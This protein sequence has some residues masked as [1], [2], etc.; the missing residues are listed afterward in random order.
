MAFFG[1]SRGLADALK[2]LEAGGI[3]SAEEL[4]ALLDAVRAHPDWRPE[5]TLWMLRSP[6]RRIREFAEQF[7]LER[8]DLENVISPLAEEIVSTPVA[9]RPE[10]AR[11]AARLAGARLPLLLPSLIH[12]ETPE[13][14][15]AALEIIATQAE[16]R[17]WLPLLRAVLN[18]PVPELRRKAARVLARNVENPSAFVALRDLIHDEDAELRRIVI[19]AFAR[20]PGPD[21]VEPFFERLPLE[22]ERER[23]VIVKA[24]ST[25]AR[26]S[27]EEVEERI[28]PML[29]DENGDVREMAVRLLSEMPDRTRL[30]RTFCLHA[31]G[32][33]FWLRERSL[34]S[35]RTIAGSLAGPLLELLQPGEEED[36]RVGAML[37]AR[38]SGNELLRARVQEIFLGDA[39]WWIRNTAAE[40]LGDYPGEETSRVLISRIREPELRLGIIALL[41]RRGGAA[42]TEA[43][44]AC[45]RDPNNGVRR[46]ALDALAHEAR[47]EL[48]GLLMQVAGDDPDAAVREK[49]S[50]LLE[51]LHGPEAAFPAG[52]PGA[53]AAPVDD[54]YDGLCM[55][56]EEL[57]RPQGSAGPPA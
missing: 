41:G 37:L 45:L 1:K 23:A 15:E 29:C 51:S 13:R 17:A 54:A 24:L 14:R 42:A 7:L 35:I 12:A 9:A 52:S 18:D 48:V 25:L 32:L 30:L 10:M 56:N 46:A 49:A 44:V 20:R 28:L 8:N 26:T 22:A 5:H 16:G 19:E 53:C 55:Q 39:D 31:R 27:Q 50:L 47:P 36:V 34:A 21:I 2:R 57:N 40:V 3:A 6:S 4:D 38:G 43:L 11:A 33:A